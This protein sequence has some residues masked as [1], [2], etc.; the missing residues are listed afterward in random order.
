[1]VLKNLF[2]IFDVDCN[3]T[4]VDVVKRFPFIPVSVLLV[5]FLIFNQN[6]KFFFKF[7]WVESVQNVK[8]FVVSDKMD[9]VSSFVFVKIAKDAH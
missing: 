4:L 3:S 9:K 5:K 2:N 1:M 8:S 6:C 7:A